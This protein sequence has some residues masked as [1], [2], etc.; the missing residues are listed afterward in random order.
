V[1]L[2]TPDAQGVSRGQTLRSAIKQAKKAQRPK[3]VI[4]RM[5]KELDAPELKPGTD[6]LLNLFR[7]LDDTRG[8][9]V[10][11]T[12]AGAVFLPRA[13][14]SQELEAFSRL[15]DVPVTPWEAATLAAMDRA[16]REESAKLRGS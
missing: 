16:Y 2:N 12:M 10:V 7:E 3:A 11:T 1:R 6:Y 4:E 8:Y 14:S 5:T 15:R 9:D 13:I